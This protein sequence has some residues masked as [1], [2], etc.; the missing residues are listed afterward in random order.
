MSSESTSARKWVLGL[1]SV[2]S[3]M[4]ALDILIVSTALDSIRTDLGTSLETLEWSVNAYNLTFAVL[5]MTAA[6]L[7][8]RFGRRRSFVTGLIVFTVASAMCALAADAGWLIVWRAVQG[9]GA[10]MVMPVSIALISTAFPPERLGRALGI[11]MGVTGLATVAGPLVGG[12][13]TQAFGWEWIFWLN[14]PIGL[15]VVPLALMRVKESK[16]PETRLDIRG[17]VLVTA[18]AFALVWGLVRGN[19]AG[20]GSVEVVT[21]LVLGVVLV[22]AFVAWEKRAP[23]PMLPLRFFR[24][25][26]FSL[27]N[28]ITFFIFAQ[29]FGSVFLMAQ[30]LQ[31]VVGSGP[32]E[33]GLQMIPWTGTMVFV[34]PI[35]GS[36]ADRFGPRP[37]IVTGLLCSAAGMLWLGLVAAPGLSYWSVVLPLLIVGVGNS[38]AIPVAQS[39][40]VGSVG[41]EA[42]GKASGA[43]GMLRELGG[44]FGI[45]IL[46]AIFAAVGGYTS[47]TTFAD[48]FAGAI[49]GC[50]AFSLIGV[51]LGVL[52]P[53]KAAAPDS[54]TPA[55]P[56]D[57][58]AEAR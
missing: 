58:R 6:A 34:A 17:N 46:V 20:W 33:S 57:E 37:V 2:V 36:L 48:G 22:G 47:S 42:A 16:G 35:A 53:R 11:Y 40:T 39:T 49:F 14:V 4:V 24:N 45:A 1:T 26:S 18:A 8:D 29:L 5:L 51:A 44:V 15:I 32:L 27:G 28:A 43:N 12:A 30:F 54:P 31:N 23:Q 41:Q 56:A 3:L 50:V 52:L 10:A 9:A 13:I 7:A 38:A 21:A 19:P 55:V 25:R